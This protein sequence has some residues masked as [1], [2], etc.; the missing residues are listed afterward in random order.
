MTAPLVVRP[1]RLTLVC[2]IVAVVV[3]AVF[4]VIATALRTAPEGAIPFG[5][6][7]QVAM[8]LLGVLVAGGVLLFTRFRVVA[9]A[10]GVAVR[11][12]LGETVLPWAVVV[13]VR[14]DEG[15]PWASLELQDDDTVALLAVQANDGERAIDAVVALRRL[16]RASREGGGAAPA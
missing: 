14:L 5:V 9:D 3:V 10:D 6:A 15:A 12:A 16:L 11:N 2:R 4:A 1:R 8:T 7:D 13:A